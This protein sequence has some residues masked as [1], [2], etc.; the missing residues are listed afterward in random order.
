MQC[1]PEDDKEC[2]NI[3]TDCHQCQVQ[4][5]CEFVCSSL[6]SQY[7]VEFRI[8]RNP[9]TTSQPSLKLIQLRPQTQSTHLLKDLLLTDPHHLP[10]KQ[11][12][13]SLCASTRHTF[14]HRCRAATD[15]CCAQIERTV[16][17]I[18]ARCCCGYFCFTCW[19]C[20]RWCCSYWL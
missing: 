20:D 19:C 2:K 3:F 12:P 14:Q 9:S 8:P 18:S 11:K 1:F 17:R 6:T 13:V 10:Q 5:T 16:V 7:H 15:A 4:P